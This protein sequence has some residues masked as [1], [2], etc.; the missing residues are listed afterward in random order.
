[1]QVA[2]SAILG[3]LPR[4]SFIA[5]AETPCAALIS[6]RAWS[7]LAELDLDNAFGEYDKKD[8]QYVD[9]LKVTAR[10]GDGGNGCVSF[11][12]SAAKG[13]PSQGVHEVH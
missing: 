6:L 4:V 1:M 3:L 11:W 2:R 8:Q 12:K 7:S 13:R 5:G 10:A 9:R